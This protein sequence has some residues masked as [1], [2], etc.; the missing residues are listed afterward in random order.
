MKL[1]VF[2]SIAV[3]IVAINS[4]ILPHDTLPKLCRRSDA[5]AKNCM[6]KQI[7]KTIHYVVRHGLR[8]Y[9]VPK[10]DPINIPLAIFER[11]VDDVAT[12]KG[13]VKNIEITGL[14][15]FA[16]TDIK[17]LDDGQNIVGE[18]EFTHPHNYITLEMD[19]AT[20]LFGTP[21][22]L[23]GYAAAN[24][25]DVRTRLKIRVKTILKGGVKYFSLD[26]LKLKSTV[27]GSHMSFLSK[28]PQAQALIDRAVHSI[29][30][31]SKQIIDFIHPY[32]A[33]TMEDFLSSEIEKVISKVPAETLLPE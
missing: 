14:S 15:N 1:L 29:N 19:I 3:Q 33:E 9:N 11:T 24:F 25:T 13:T 32:Y 16:F 28:N 31:N 20:E 10:M 2:I 7:D 21:I 8:K 22:T 26:H 17:Y 6:V 12:V 18:L 5:D 4:K 30:E 27:G 23:E